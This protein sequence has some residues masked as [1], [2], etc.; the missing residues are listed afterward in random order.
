MPV[1]PT[2]NDITAFL[3]GKG[4]REKRRKDRNL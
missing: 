4:K 3:I 1:V 2:P